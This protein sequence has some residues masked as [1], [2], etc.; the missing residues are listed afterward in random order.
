MSD[1]GI[2][3]Q[4][5]VD[6][7]RILNAGGYSQEKPYAVGGSPEALF[8]VQ[9]PSYIF[10]TDAEKT[11]LYK[12]WLVSQGYFTR[13]TL[14]APLARTLENI[15]NNVAASVRTVIPTATPQSVSHL[16]LTSVGLLAL[17]WYFK[18]R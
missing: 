14:V 6:A 13:V 4:W 15:S 3:A 17:F 2:P 8:L 11:E 7:L 18:G 16:L 10:S 12:N 1:F 5:K 9:N